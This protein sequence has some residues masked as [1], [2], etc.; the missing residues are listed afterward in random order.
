MTKYE[1][2][3]Q[4]MATQFHIEIV[5]EER[6]IAENVA[7]LCFN[8]IDELEL[9]LSRFVPDSDISH[10]NRMQSGDEF[11]LEYETWEVLKKS[12]KIQQFTQGAFHIGI[13]EFMNIFRA[14]KEGILS[15]FEMTNA[16]KIAFKEM[17]SASVF[18][19]PETPKIYCIHQGMKFD[20]GAIGKGFAL[21]QI[22]VLLKEMEIYNYAINI[23]NSTVLVKGR[24]KE[25]KF[26][27]FT[28]S[29]SQ[30]EIPLELNDI[31]ISASGS[32]YQ[33][34]HI[35]DPRTGLNSFEKQYD[36]VWVASKS[37]AVSD[38]YA[39][40]CFLLEKPVLEEIVVNNPQVVWIA[41]SEKGKIEF[42]GK[43]HLPLKQTER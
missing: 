29:S 3:H 17:Q 38:A 9:I 31:A 30:E 33:G 24:S 6:D 4:A 8:R 16:L 1:F 41:V 28:L 2:E 37:A 32:F 7:N 36:R 35:F 5:G 34:N 40:A 20:L 26:W 39:T 43:N 14:T 27:G 22:V 42:I 21:D 23:G 15:E 11:M 10:I 12:V 18:I 25:D 13:A 19:D